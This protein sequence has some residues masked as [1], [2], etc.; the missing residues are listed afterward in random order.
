MG[1]SGVRALVSTKKVSLSVMCGYETESSISHFKFRAVPKAP[2]PGRANST[3]G[4]KLL[5]FSESLAE[6]VC[7]Q[8]L[9]LVV[10]SG[11]R[12]TTR[13]PGMESRTLGVPR[14]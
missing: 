2:S 1:A 10:A 4:V 6:M 8:E 9:L 13:A 3:H 7:P 5:D 12:C 14:Q 11:K